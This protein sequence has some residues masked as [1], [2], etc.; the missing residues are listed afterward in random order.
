M[1]NYTKGEWKVESETEVVCGDRLIANTGG[2]TNNYSFPRQE[3]I[4]NAHLIAAAPEL[5]KALKFF[6]E[7]NASEYVYLDKGIGTATDIGKAFLKA[8]KTLAKVEGK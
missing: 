8:R 3:N 6:V 5:Y 2:Y 4:A 7:R 1:A